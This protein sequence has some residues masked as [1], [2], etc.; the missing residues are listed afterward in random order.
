MVNKGYNIIDNHFDFIQMNWL[1]N[2]KRIDIKN[3]PMNF[4]KKIAKFVKNKL[5]M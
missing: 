5:K 1:K 3:M 2:I 4:K